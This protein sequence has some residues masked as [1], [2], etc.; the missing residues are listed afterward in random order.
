[1]SEA[2]IEASKIDWKDDEALVLAVHPEALSIRR[3]D[4]AYSVYPHPGICEFYL[5]QSLVVSN[6]S[7]DAWRLARQHPTVQAFEKANRPTDAEGTSKP[8][9]PVA[10]AE[11]E[12]QPRKV[13]KASDIEALN[14]DKHSCGNHVS[15]KN[16]DCGCMCGRTYMKSDR[17]VLV[18]G[19]GRGSKSC[20]CEYSQPVAD[21]LGEPQESI[22]RSAL[23]E[24]IATVGHD[25]DFKPS[26]MLNSDQNDYE[27]SKNASAWRSVMAEPLADAVLAHLASKPLPAQPEGQ[28]GDDYLPP[29]DVTDEEYRIA[30]SLS[31]HYREYGVIAQLK[32]QLACRERQLRAASHPRAF[33]EQAERLYKA[34]DELL[35]TLPEDHCGDEHCGGDCGLYRRAQKALHEYRAVQGEA[36]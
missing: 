5:A 31:K 12:S 7:E 30:C 34:L 3:K 29:L 19:Y 10:P 6:N 27:R 1:M 32:S 22:D 33:D 25:T 35:E 14:S 9:L 36:K 23:V 4:G 20:T 11:G 16:P 17:S 13:L 18:L 21:Y 8:T 2:R 15:N 28:K 26:R 24:L